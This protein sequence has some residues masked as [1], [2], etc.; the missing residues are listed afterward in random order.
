MSVVS[1][2]T[3]M[4]SRR[5]A[6]LGLALPPVV[7]QALGAAG[8]VR[9]RGTIVGYEAGQVTIQRMQVGRDGVPPAN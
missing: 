3:P 7:V 6:A 2:N 5:H 4:L 8:A 1:V 9:I